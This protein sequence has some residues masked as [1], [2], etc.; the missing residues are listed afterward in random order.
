MSALHYAAYFDVPELIRVVLEAARPGGESRRRA[1][2]RRGQECRHTDTD[3]IPSHCALL[4]VLLLQK[5]TPPA[6]TSTLAPP[7]ISPRPTCASLPSSACCRWGPTLPS[8]CVRAVGM[9]GC[10]RQLAEGAGRCD[11]TAV[12]NRRV[13]AANKQV[14]DICKPSAGNGGSLGGG[15]EQVL[16]FN[17]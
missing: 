14:W 2:D 12:I 10:G 15:F 5:W 6:A 17:S 9:G 8:G 3:A 11:I 13:T 4:P 1:G 7:C 16:L